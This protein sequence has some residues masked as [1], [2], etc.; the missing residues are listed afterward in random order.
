MIAA[1]SLPWR[2]LLTLFVALAILTACVPPAPLDDDPPQRDTATPQVVIALYTPLPTHTPVPTVNLTPALTPPHDLGAGQHIAVDG[3]Y[4]ATETDAAGPMVCQIQRNSAAFQH[5]INNTD[6]RL[7]W[8]GGDPDSL[9]DENHF[10]HQAMLAPLD[11][12]IGLVANEWGGQ[13]QMMVTAAYDSTGHHDLAQSA[14]AR[15][16]SLH[17]EGR[18]IDLIPW[19]PDLA[20]IARLC[21]LA[22]IAGFDWVHNEADHCHASVKTQSLCNLYNYHASS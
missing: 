5:L 9:P 1:A 17:F 12:L 2:G 19:P 13:T 10:M 15:K 16:Y 8:A 4:A 22:H 21:A 20:K 3:S 18:S 14:Q 6:S 7:L 11:T